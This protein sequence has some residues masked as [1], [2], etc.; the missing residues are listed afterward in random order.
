MKL[1]CF[2]RTLKYPD[3]QTVSFHAMLESQSVP[4]RNTVENREHIVCNPTSLSHAKLSNDMASFDCR[5]IPRSSQ[6]QSIH[7]GANL[8]NNGFKDKIQCTPMEVHYPYNFIMRSENTDG[9]QRK[10]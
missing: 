4:S 8:L 9:A 1:K 7:V 6:S 10:G 2:H 5:S 3:P